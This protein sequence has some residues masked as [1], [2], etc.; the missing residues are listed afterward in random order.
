MYKIEKVLQEKPETHEYYEDGQRTR[1]QPEK[2]EEVRVCR[3]MKCKDS[4]SLRKEGAIVSPMLSR[5]QVA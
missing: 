2:Q 4:V 3:G 5:G 1:E